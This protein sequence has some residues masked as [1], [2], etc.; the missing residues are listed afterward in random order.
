MTSVEYH[1]HKAVSKSD[2]DLINRSPLHYYNAKQKPNEQTEA[3]LFGSV[4]HKMILE[5][6]TFAAG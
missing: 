1:A 2:L 4:V 3:M 6:D 5:P